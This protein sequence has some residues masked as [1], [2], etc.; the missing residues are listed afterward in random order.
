MGIT[1]IEMFEGKPPYSD[2]HPMRAIFMIPTKPSPTFKDEQKCSDQIRGFVRKC[3]VKSAGDRASAAELL[4]DDFITSHRD[5]NLDE[6]IRDVDSARQA[7]PD[8]QKSRSKVIHL[9][10]FF[11]K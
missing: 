1:A 10:G 3:L 11:K 2:I 6:L 8:F 5:S 9:C 7:N 4:Q